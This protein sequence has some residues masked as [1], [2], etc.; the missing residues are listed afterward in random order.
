MPDPAQALAVRR[1]GAFEINLQSGELRKN[2]IRLRLSGQ[3]FQVLALLVE[4]AGEAVTR[5]ELQ[6]KLWSADTFVDF[7]HGLNN[8]VARI[9]EVLDD[10]SD[11]P[12]YVE[13]I[14]RRG[15]RFIAPMTGVSPAI[16]I[17]RPGNSGSS[18][19][20]AEKRLTFFRL[21]VLLGGVL[22][23]FSFAFMMYHNRN[24][25]VIGPKQPAIKSL[26]V[27]PL[28]N[29]SGEPGQEY[30]ADGMTEALIGRLSAI[31]D[32]RV[33]SRTSVMSLKDTKLS[34]PDIAKTLRVDALVEGSV[35]REGGRIRVYAQLI[36]GATDEHFWSETYDRELG[37]ALALE[38]EV[39]QAIASRVQVTV[40]GEERQ[41]LVAAR[42]VA[43]EVY[44]SYLKGQFAKG[45]SR[46]DIERSMA[47]FEDAIHKDPTFAPAYLGVAAAYERFGTVFVGLPP[48]ETRPKAVAAAQKAL[49]FDPD[50]AEAHVLLGGIY[51]RQWRWSDAEFEYK[52]ALQ[53]KPNDAGAHVG[54][55]DWLMCQGRTDEALTRSMRARELDPI[56]VNGSHLGWIMFEA[57]HYDDAI[58]ELRSD[59]AVH[60]DSAM[61]HWFLGFVLIEDGR[62]AEAIPELEKT[63]SLMN[64]SSGAIGVLIRAYARA[65]RRADALRM[66]AELKKRLESEYVPAAAF[67]NAYLGLEDYDQTFMWLEKAYEE[68]SN[69][70]QFL[71]VPF[72]DPIR[73]D[74]RFKDLQRRVG[75]N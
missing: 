16:E 54:L 48:Q 60:P 35:I 47:F 34:A 30:L 25:V 52:R 7:D 69:I 21:M 65:G 61:A 5:E 24:S 59:L 53:L 37:Q 29:L 6:S 70:L 57:R 15:Y 28:K 32:L 44:E 17:T 56:G 62:P 55:A 75:L 46:A 22:A 3:P 50:L 41:R 31:R 45:N 23:L 10:S 4:H 74:S 27:L 18:V 68:Q 51:Q 26:A 67:V 8:A 49:E 73:N 58:R 64:R 63:V 43:P 2:G 19:L 42:H 14:P 36:R 72:F 12:R 71:R 38:S 9:R 33:I 20:S 13:T 40:T 11:K 39:A 1:F 66:L